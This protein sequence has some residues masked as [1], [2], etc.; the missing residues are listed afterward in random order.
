MRLHAKLRFL[1][2]MLAMFVLT[3]TFEAWAHGDAQ[4]AQTASAER[5]IAAA[6]SKASASFHLLARAAVDQ[7]SRQKGCG[8]AAC[9]VSVCASCCSMVALEFQVAAPL[10]STLR[11]DLPLGLPQAGLGPDRIRRPPKT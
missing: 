1:A 8:G 4:H 3:P 9:C 11:L 7:G 5:H 10:P 6:D 2:V